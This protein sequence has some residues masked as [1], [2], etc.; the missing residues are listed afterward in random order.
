MII[1]DTKNGVAFVNDKA[2]KIVEHGKEQARV[3]VYEG[4]RASIFHDVISVRYVSDNK[5]VDIKENGNELVDLQKKHKELLDWGTKLRDEFNKKEE[6]IGILKSQIID[7]V[8]LVTKDCG[9]DEMRNEECFST[10]EAAQEYCDYY[11]KRFS[12]PR[13]SFEIWGIRR[14]FNDK[15]QEQ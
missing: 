5:E 7:R 6:E 4:E 14:E 13:Y 8:Y 3:K 12:R 11:N 15:T 1:I 2:I 10:E 9:D